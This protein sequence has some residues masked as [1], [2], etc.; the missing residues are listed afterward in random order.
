MALSEGS[1]TSNTY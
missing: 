1:C